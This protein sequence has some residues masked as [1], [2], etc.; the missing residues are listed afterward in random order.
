MPVQIPA[1][2]HGQAV[3]PEAVLPFEVVEGVR[4]EGHED[5]GARETPDVLDELPAEEEGEIGRD[6]AADEAADGVDEEADDR[7]VL[8]PEA[9]GQR[10]DG[11]DADAHRD[12]AD[13]GDKGLG[14]PVVV[15]SEDVVAEIREGSVLER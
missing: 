15:G 8:L 9:L 1:A 12:A 11:E 2:A 10:P 7:H 6:E 14:D 3:G 5:I 4:E 13:D